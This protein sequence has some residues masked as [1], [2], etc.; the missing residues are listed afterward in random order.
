MASLVRWSV[1][2][3]YVV[4]PFS[5]A[6]AMMSALRERRISAVELLDLHINRIEEHDEQLNA[7]VIQAFDRARLVAEAADAAWG[8][9]EDRPLLGLPMTVKE[10][11]HVMGMPT[12][13]GIP[14]FAGWQPDGNA[15]LVQRV[16]NAGAAIIGKTNISVSLGDWVAD[17]P[18]YGR[19][20]NPWDLGRSPGGSTGGGGAALAAG[21]TPLE[22]GSD[23]GGSIRV[24]A[25]F[26]GVYGHRPS[27]SAVPRT[28]QFPNRLQLP[29]PTVW[30]GVQGPLARSAEDLELAFDI[31]AGPDVGEDVAWKLEI[32]AARHESLSTCRVAIM[33]PVPWLPVDDETLAAQDHL[34]RVLESAGATVAETQPALFGDLEELMG[35]Y[36]RLLTAIVSAG[37][38]ADDRQRDA[39]E[40]RRRGDLIGLAIA[41]GL[42]ADSV[43]YREWHLERER[44]RESY[45]EFFREWDILVCPSMPAPAFEHPD[46]NI[47]NHERQV[48]VNGQPIPY[49]HQILYPAVATYCGQP[50]TAFP[51]GFNSA[52]LPLGL[53]AI[54]PYL[55]DRTP[56]RFAGLVTCE[57]G[58]FQP[59]LGY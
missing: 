5:T 38:S 46:I 49:E 53:Q 56:M 21:L 55:E 18:V 20:N 11:F 16:L 47:P 58:G 10:S 1:E 48:T 42:T 9:G 7:V 32:P 39:A 40:A 22:F 52:G 3:G 57:I 19:T 4:D 35:L 41:E 26:C 13:V 17:N 43:E 50:S 28:G 8:R 33:P 6:T 36:Y 24:P 25:T 30:M 51:V 54:G 45:R 59:P 34:V 2:K 14:D 23:I 29:N 15:L 37:Q 27:D 44:Y 12:C 31:V